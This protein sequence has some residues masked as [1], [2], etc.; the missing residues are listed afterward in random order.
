[1][2]FMVKGLSG[3]LS[4]APIAAEYQDVKLGPSDFNSDGISPERLSNAKKV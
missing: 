3:P 4:D 1:M 2:G